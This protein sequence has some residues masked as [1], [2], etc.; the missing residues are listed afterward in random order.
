MISL[1][2][3]DSSEEDLL[4]RSLVPHSPGQAWP[5]GQSLEPELMGNGWEHWMILEMWMAFDGPK[6]KV[7]FA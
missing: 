6:K 1:I 4:D 7:G 2:N 3:Y 5:G